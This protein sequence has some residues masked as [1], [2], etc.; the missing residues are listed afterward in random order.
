ML[1]FPVV[2]LPIESSFIF[3]YFL[4]FAFYFVFLRLAFSP[5][6]IPSLNLLAFENILLF[7]PLVY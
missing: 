3:S 1:H 5:E 7:M 6:L 4:L 2:S